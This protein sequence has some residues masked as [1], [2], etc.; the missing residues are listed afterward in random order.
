[1]L[2]ECPFVIKNSS[3]TLMSL[4]AVNCTQR[5]TAQ[6]WLICKIVMIS[7]TFRHSPIHSLPFLIHSSTTRRWCAFSAGQQYRDYRYWSR[8]KM[9]R[10]HRGPANSLRTTRPGCAQDG[11]Q[12]STHLERRKNDEIQCQGEGVVGCRTALHTHWQALRHPERRSKFCP[13]AHTARL[14]FIDT[15]RFDDC[16]ER[17]SMQTRALLLEGYVTTPLIMSTFF[18]F[19]SAITT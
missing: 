6:K 5:N 18:R 16:G 7:F 13:T 15:V 9:S 1:M 10:D 14:R 8:K 12:C 4:I 11:T 2:C 19:A 3:L 17:E